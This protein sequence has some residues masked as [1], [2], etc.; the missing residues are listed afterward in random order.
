M[1]SAPAVSADARDPRYE[2]SCV[3]TDRPV[4]QSRG[5]R[6]RMARRE[7]YAPDQRRA[8]RRA[9]RNAEQTEPRPLIK[10]HRAGRLVNQIKKLAED[11]GALPSVERS[12]DPKDDFLLAMCEAGQADYLVTGDKSGLLALENHAPAKIVSA[13]DFAALFERGAKS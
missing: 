9:A 7:I 11:V 10:P 8:G 4:R 6:R 3:R 2:Y 12:P 5:H 13:R 1:P